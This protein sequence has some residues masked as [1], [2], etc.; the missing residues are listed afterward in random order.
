[1]TRILGL[2]SVGILSVLHFYIAYFEMFAWEARGPAVFPSLDPDLFSKT[3]AMAFN[4]GVY[5]AF[6][7]AGLAW[8]LIIRDRTWQFNVAVCFLL[9]VAVAGVAGAATISPRILVIQTVPAILGVVLL[10]L[11]RRRTDVG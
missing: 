6:I 8:S 9:F 11:S 2:A 5:N 7:A 3:T 1:M 10:V 4:Q